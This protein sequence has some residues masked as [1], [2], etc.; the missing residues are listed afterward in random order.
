MHSSLLLCTNTNRRRGL[1][2]TNGVFVANCQR[3][4][5]KSSYSVVYIWPFLMIQRVWRINSVHHPFLVQ[6][7]TM[8][9][10]YLFLGSRLGNSLLLKYTEKLQETPAE[11]GKDKQDKEKERERQASL[12]CK[13]NTKIRSL[14]PDKF[15]TLQQKLCSNF[16]WTDG[17]EEMIFSLLTDQLNYV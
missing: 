12:P 5:E 14:F 4:G 8:E 16:Y 15:G 13:C 1:L 10:G 17:R 9:P 7:V 2:W 11:E 6:M 3:R